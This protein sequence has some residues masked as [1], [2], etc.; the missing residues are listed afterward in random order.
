[1]VARGK[2]EGNKL[3]REFGMDM[4]T[5][6]YLKQITNKDLLYSTKKSAQCYVAAWRGVGFGG[7]WIH[8]YVW[9]SP[10][11]VNLELLQK[12]KMGLTPRPLSFWELQAR[13]IPLP[14]PANRGY[15][16]FLAQRPFIHSQ[17]QQLNI[18]KSLS[19]TDSTALIFHLGVL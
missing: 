15:P 12:C 8:V 4:Y 7:E 6:L 18:F 10:S 9:L 3:V 17:T 19:D 16:H 2:D 13:I 14:F 5:L 11:A 1:M